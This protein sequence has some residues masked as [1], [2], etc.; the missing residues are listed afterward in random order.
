MYRNIDQITAEL[1]VQHIKD[2]ARK[3]ALADACISAT[4]EWNDTATAAANSPGVDPILTPLI[5]LKL[6]TSKVAE[7]YAA[8]MQNID[9][10]NKE[11]DN[12]LK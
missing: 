12:K 6:V 3:K 8:S 10:E 4:T 7:L 1:Y 2:D 11:R 5:T 9:K